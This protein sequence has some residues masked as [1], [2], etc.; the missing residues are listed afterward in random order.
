M[1]RKEC[2]EI[3]EIWLGDDWLDE[4]LLNAMDYARSFLLAAEREEEIN[5]DGVEW[6]I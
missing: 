3:L 6:L 1:T 5:F 2:I 4:D